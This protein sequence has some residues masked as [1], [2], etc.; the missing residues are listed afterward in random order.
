MEGDAED[1]HEEDSEKEGRI[2]PIGYFGPD[3]GCHKFVS[4]YDRMLLCAA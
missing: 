4:W 1:G 3:Q 2:G